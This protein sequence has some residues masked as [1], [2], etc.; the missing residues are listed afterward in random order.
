MRKFT[1]LV[2][3]F[4]LLVLFAIPT[5]SFANNQPSSVTI[6]F[7]Y[8]RLRSGP[9]TSSSVITMVNADKTYTYLGTSAADS[10]GYPW[11]KLQYTSSQVSYVRS[12]LA[13]LN[14][15]NTPAPVTSGSLIVN[16]SLG[17]NM[18]TGPGTNYSIITTI[19]NGTSLTFSDLQ[20]GWYKVS[21]SGQTGWIS[22]DYVRNVTPGGTAPT[23]APTPAP[24]PAPTPSP[25]KGSLTVIATLG[26]NVRTQAGLHGAIMG[27][28]P[29]NSTASYINQQN[30]WYQVNYG[31]GTGW[32][33]GDFVRT[34][35]TVTPPSS[36]TISSRQAQWLDWALGRFIDVEGDGVS[37][38]TELTRQYA[39]DLFGHD[40]GLR[41][42]NGNQQIYTGSGDYFEKIFWNADDPSTYPKRGDIISWTGA[43]YS[44]GHVAIVLEDQPDRYGRIKTLTTSFG[45]PYRPAEIAYMNFSDSYNG[46]VIGMLRPIQSKITATHAFGT[47]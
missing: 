45:S 3:A 46:T 24:A 7:D 8:V 36:G 12:D 25:T 39:T 37:W 18:R 23:P 34:N 33:S 16:A 4:V 35:A 43:L 19:A 13:T 30:G 42:G 31:N 29:Y 9:N 28:L 27:V 2:L 11:Y 41:M 44:A 10:D 40:A 22:G 17:L 6:K 20:N 1:S 15:S 38:C 14:Y 21:Y 47:R 26:L 32:V 5:E